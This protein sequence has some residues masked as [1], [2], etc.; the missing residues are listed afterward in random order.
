MA[1][2]FRDWLRGLRGD[3]DA[4]PTPRP[5]LPGDVQTTQPMTS[6]QAQDIE[7]L[8]T[9]LRRIGVLDARP[10]QADPSLLAALQRL[11]Q[12]GAHDLAVRFGA[13][14]TAAI[15]SDHELALRVAGW[16]QR[17]GNIE[18][19]QALTD[20][21][22]AGA[23]GDSAQ[24]HAAPTAVEQQ[25]RLLR[26]E[27]RLR[28]G[29]ASGS[30]ADLADLLI[31]EWPSAG[32]GPTAPA[33]ARFRQGRTSA[34]AQ[35]TSRLPEPIRSGLGAAALSAA[36]T[37]LG[38]LTTARYRLL[39]ELGAGKNGVVYAV[40]DTQ[41]GCELAL[42]LFD[43]G[44]DANQVLDEAKLLS[45]LHHPGVLAL[46]DPDPEGRFLTME[47]CRGGSLR[48][49]LRRETLSL[50]IALRRTAELCEALAAVHAVGICHG[51]IKPENLLFR[52]PQVSLRAIEG[53][54]AF[55]DL[56]ISDFGIAERL[57]ATDAPA[58]HAARGTRAYLAPERLHGQ[59]GSPA[60]DLYS[61]GVVLFEMRT[62]A[63][64]SAP[65]GQ[66]PSVDEIAQATASQAAAAPVH[67]LLCA[68]LSS[69][70]TQRPGAAQVAQILASLLTPGSPF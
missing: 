66:A 30:Q 5:A 62:G 68:L 50:P 48:A 14:L 35:R 11:W 53:D 24:P 54:E 18:A 51:D 9:Q 29:D 37:L 56:V 6:P 21:I 10:Q 70:P 55:G 8:S 67:A 43:A 41:L 26:S 58:K 49:R 15:P 33:L 57:A 17:Q 45:A 38:E 59:P 20:R 22:L 12:A 13:A 34:A 69:Q 63:V 16:L 65:V 27:L 64:P 40:E 19:A 31:A 7:L 1:G 39:S 36:P 47:L 32:S 28:L 44:I 52:D 23:D 42:K 25:A 60:A 46:Y 3:T 61:V 4:A 2:R